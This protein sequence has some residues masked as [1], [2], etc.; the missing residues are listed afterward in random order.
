MKLNFNPRTWHNWVGV[1]LSLP[2]LVVSVTAVFIAHNHALELREVDVTRFVWWLPA[3]GEAQTQAMKTEIRAS[4]STADGQRW[5]GSKDGLYQVTD[6]RARQ[7]DALGGTEV[8]DIVAAPFGLVVATSK[9]LWLKD[10]KGW[11]KVRKGDAWSVNLNPDGQVAAGLKGEGVLTSRNGRDWILD[12]TAGAALA[13]VPRET[14]VPKPIT[15]HNLVMDLHTGKAFFGK[16]WEWIWIDLVGL[17]MAFLGGSGVW[18]WW[19]GEQRKKA[20]L[21]ADKTVS[22]SAAPSASAEAA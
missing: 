3:Y 16:E 1:I 10:A 2:I 15:L 11:T 12:T 9:G 14:L 22:R 5:L 21:Q 17:V 20:L 18:M 7:V 19:R 4:L 6:G 8:R 13:A